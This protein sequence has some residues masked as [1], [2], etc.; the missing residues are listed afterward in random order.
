M[1][2]KTKAFDAA[3]YFEGDDHSQADLIN[4]ALES[5]NA[6]YI[7][8]ALGTVAKSR[9]MTNVAAD[10]GLNRQALYAA[11]KEGA[12]PTLDTVL[13]VVHALGLELTTRERTLESA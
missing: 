1:A 6:G 2:T 10:T 4:D 13:K 12:N 9:G 8:A 3:K 11:L 5:G 7:A